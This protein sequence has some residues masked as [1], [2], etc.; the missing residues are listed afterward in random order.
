MDGILRRTL[1]GKFHG[2]MEMDHNILAVK[3]ILQDVKLEMCLLHLHA[4]SE[5]STRAD[6]QKVAS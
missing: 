6:G 1:S 2:L 5:G 4:P 3:K